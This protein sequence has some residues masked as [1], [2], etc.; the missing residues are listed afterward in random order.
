MTSQAKRVIYLVI[1]VSLVFNAS[2]LQAQTEQCPDLVVNGLIALQPTDGLSATITATVH[3]I[4]QGSIESPFVVSLLDFVCC[5]WEAGPQHVL[6]SESQLNQLN[7]DGNVTILF[8]EVLFP[9]DI[10]PCFTCRGTFVV[11]AENDIDESCH[12]AP[13]GEDNNVGCPD[14]AIEIT[15]STC[16][17]SGCWVPVP[18][19]RCIS[20]LFESIMEPPRCWQWVTVYGP[21]QPTC[22]VEL[23]Y[24]IR[25]V[26]TQDAGPF[27]VGVQGA[28]DCVREIPV[29][30][31]LAMG[32]KLIQS[33][34]CTVQPEWAPLLSAVLTITADSKHNIIHGRAPENNTVNV[35]LNCGCED[36]DDYYL[37]PPLQTTCSEAPSEAYVDLTIS[38]RT[39]CTSTSG[40]PGL[41]GSWVGC[42][43]SVD[44]LV[45]VGGEGA[46]PSPLAIGISD[47][48]C[49][50]DLR[51]SAERQLTKHEIEELNEHRAVV[52]TDAF[53][54]VMPSMQGENLCCSYTL[55]VD[56]LETVQEC[57]AGAEEN[58]TY[59]DTYLCEPAEDCPDIVIEVLRDRCRCDSEPVTERQCLEW[60]VATYPPVCLRWGE[61]VV[62]YEGS[63][64]GRVYYKV[65]NVGTEA[66]GAFWVRME[67]SAGRAE[68]ALISSLAPGEEAT[69]W[70][71]FSA[72]DAHTLDVVL[73]ADDRDDVEECDE[74]N[75]TVEIEI[76]C[77]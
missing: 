67:T 45:S 49:G 20:W 28:E 11:D 59:T 40:L 32:E 61:V 35:S 55:T 75:N 76:R 27:T 19:E 50:K 64:E 29:A 39:R 36:D 2:L 7:A 58:N 48:V 12:S 3:N 53:R 57:P 70:F 26:G 5:H 9:S 56:S 69:R 72:G 8:P 46:L 34:S 24:V 74:Q 77:R 42:Q 33:L 52:L 73:A 22:N 54:W 38:G 21:P 6:L 63:C 62:G 65:R 47:V 13:A 16:E 44:A 41:P 17:C 51:I 18:E 10:S 31:G 1:A 4:G 43:F 60:N 15:Q 68:A 71:N 23:E 30:A 66:T 37:L 25:N 14:L